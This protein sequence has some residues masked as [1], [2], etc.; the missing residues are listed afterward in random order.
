MAIDPG[1]FKILDTLQLPEIGATPHIIVPYNGKTAIYS[2]AAKNVYRSFWD[3]ATKKLSP[4]NSWVASPLKQGQSGGDAPTSIGNWICIQTNGVGSKTAAST[5]VC[6]NK[7]NAKDKKTIT[8]FGELKPGQQR[9]APPKPTGNLTT[10]W[11]VDARS[12]EFQP[13]IGTGKNQ[14]QIF[15]KW[16]PNAK[17]GNI[18]TSTYGEQVVWRDPLTGKQI[19]ASDFLPPI[20]TNA[21]V[22]P[23]YGGRFYYPAADGS[24]YILQPMPKSSVPPTPE[25]G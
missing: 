21:L 13:V 8:P 10:K 12:F 6:I 18:A 15:T 2:A 9:L 25:K 14:V 11:I 7:D 23:G 20:S 22:A 24:L 17:L 16:D 19:A 5:L 1:S 3:P 4:D